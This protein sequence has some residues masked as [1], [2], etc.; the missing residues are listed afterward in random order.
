M[1]RSSYADKYPAAAPVYADKYADPT[2]VPTY[3]KSYVPDRIY[4]SREPAYPVSEKPVMKYVA[5]VYVAE[6]PYAAEYK[7]PVY[8][9]ENIAYNYKL[10]EKYVKYP[11][12]AY[13]DQQEYSITP[14]GNHR[15]RLASTLKS[16]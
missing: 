6:K 15:S 13:L 8:G 10:H 2:C 7:V 12:P 16:Y 9:P 4:A 5:P 3:E 14:Y 11:V 1:R